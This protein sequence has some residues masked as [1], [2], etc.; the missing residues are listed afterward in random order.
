MRSP[1]RL[2]L[3]SKEQHKDL[4][5]LV[6]RLAT[7][8]GV[9]LRARIVL[10]AAAGRSNRQLASE[11]HTSVPTVAKWLRRWTAN[12]LAG[13]KNEESHSGRPT[14]MDEI[15]DASMIDAPICPEL[16]DSDLCD[17]HLAA[18]ASGLNPVIVERIWSSYGLNRVA[19]SGFQFRTSPDT[20]KGLRDFVGLY[21]SPSQRALLVSAENQES[22]ASGDRQQCLDFDQPEALSARS[23]DTCAERVN[24]FMVVLGLM[25]DEMITRCPRMERDQEFLDFL[26]QVNLAVGRD[27]AIH[28]FMDNYRA[29]RS[30]R[31]RT[32]IGKHPRY[33][34]HFASL[35]T[36]W[37]AQ[38]LDWLKTICRL[39]LQPDAFSNSVSLIGAVLTYTSPRDPAPGPFQW[40]TSPTPVRAGEN[41]P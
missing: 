12:G 17:S 7:P 10:G 15:R 27:L 41:S 3:L 20:A 9:A 6:R 31:V 38:V 18:A 2:L 23:A 19:I 30:A 40:T 35:D 33:H 22:R 26:E 13:I 11:L 32:W 21:I 28:S 37:L 8:Q 25:C 4:E 14:R 34:L 29:L 36:P 1:A 24:T 16:A 39:E 5:H